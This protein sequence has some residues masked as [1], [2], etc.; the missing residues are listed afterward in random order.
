MV[1]AAYVPLWSSEIVKVALVNAGIVAA[2][3]EQRLLPAQGLP[4][5]RILVPEDRLVEARA[6]IDD[7]I[8]G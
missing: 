7:V 1:E 4:M 5:A 3:F 6:L 8:V 2:V